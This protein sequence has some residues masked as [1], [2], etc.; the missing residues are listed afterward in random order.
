MVVENRAGVYK[1]RIIFWD[2]ARPLP[3][4]YIYIYI[5]S[6]FSFVFGR[7]DYD[8]KETSKPLVS[9]DTFE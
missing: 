8:P 4:M 6:E 3:E 9:T 2:H 7:E 5:S 1:L